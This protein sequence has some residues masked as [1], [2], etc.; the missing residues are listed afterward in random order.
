MINPDIFPPINASLNALS[1]L[2]IATG[3]IMIRQERKS[4]HIVCMISALATSTLFLAC[5]LTYHYLKHGH[6]TY[7]THPGWPRTFYL[8]LLGTHT[9]LAI[10]VLPMII[11]TVVPALRSRW[12]K[13]RRIARWTMPVWLYVSFTGVLVYFWLYQWFPPAGA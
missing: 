10:A 11:C 4:A 6:V 9:V 13:H 1:T 3:W 7:F 2:F 12:D 8:W 5:Y